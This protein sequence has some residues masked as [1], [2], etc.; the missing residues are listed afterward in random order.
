LVAGVGNVFFGDDGF[1][2]VAARRL[3]ERELPDHVRV[4]DFGIGS[5]HLSFE[6]L[7]GYDTV[8]IVDGVVRGG[9]PG[10]IYVLEP[11]LDAARTYAEPADA[12]TVDPDAVVAMVAASPACPC[13]VLVVGC[14]PASTAPVMELSA[15]VAAAVDRACDAVIEIV[16]R[17]P[18]G[19]R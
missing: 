1:G 10:T 9:E 13:R 18:V 5:I 19:E 3:L 2:S 7:G 14:E 8:I 4:V 15:P 12:H 11:D 16:D 17:E 6:L